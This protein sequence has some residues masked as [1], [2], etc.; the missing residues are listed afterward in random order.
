MYF[1]LLVS[2]PPHLEDARG[3]YPD[4]LP[5]VKRAHRTCQ[6]CGHWLARVAARLAR[7]SAH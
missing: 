6:A 7:P 5:R 3:T 4:P 1:A 2:Q